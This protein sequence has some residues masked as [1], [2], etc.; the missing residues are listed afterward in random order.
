MVGRVM[1]CKG[2]APLTNEIKIFKHCFTILPGPGSLYPRYLVAARPHRL[3][4]THA[5]H[6]SWWRRSP[7]PGRKSTPPSTHFTRP[8]I[9][10]AI[11]GIKKRPSNPRP[12]HLPDP[13][14]FCLLTTSFRSHHVTVTDAGFK[15]RS[16]R[17]PPS[18]L[19]CS[20]Q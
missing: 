2:G 8:L 14:S 20:N 13:C 16:L 15:P 6:L 3:I 4:I 19:A 9:I 11:R 5:K 18:R 1:E 7:G 10:P 17:H 12:V